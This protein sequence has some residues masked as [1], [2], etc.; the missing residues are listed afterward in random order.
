MGNTD[1]PF[2]SQTNRLDLELSTKS[3]P[4]HGTPRLHQTPK[5][6]FHETGSRPLLGSLAPCDPDHGLRTGLHLDPLYAHDLM[7]ASPELLIGF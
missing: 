1:T 7:G 3:T 5:L 2:A 4:F 6:G